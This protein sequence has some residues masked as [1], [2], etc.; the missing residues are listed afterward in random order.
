M[1]FQV[2]IDDLQF[3]FDCKSRSTRSGFAHDCVLR[4]A[5]TDKGVNVYTA[6]SAC[7]CN[8][9]WETYRYETV[10]LKALNQTREMYFDIEKR[11]MSDMLD[12]KRFS[13]KRL[14]KLYLQLENNSV[15]CAIRKALDY[16]YDYDKAQKSVIVW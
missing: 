14:E 5:N 12:W 11:T 6:V 3:T 4:I 9:T 1:V 15:Y 10:I 13:A 2:T 16:M 8:R 7:Y